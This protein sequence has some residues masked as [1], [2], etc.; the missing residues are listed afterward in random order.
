MYSCRCD[1]LSFMQYHLRISE[2]FPNRNVIFS[3]WHDH[4]SASISK[5]ESRS[6]ATPGEIERKKSAGEQIVDYCAD[7]AAE[8]FGQQSILKIPARD[9]YCI[10]AARWSIRR[11]YSR[12]I[13]L[14]SLLH[15]RALHNATRATMSMT[16]TTMTAMRGRAGE[17]RKNRRKRA[18][19]RVEPFGARL[20][21]LVAPRR[22]RETRE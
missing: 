16:M 6:Y 15:D 14:P 10:K 8:K 21:R 9:R 4:R 1:L 2:Y 11:D 5:N 12:L 3:L 13:D 22:E 17:E 20:R 18:M 7:S 19:A